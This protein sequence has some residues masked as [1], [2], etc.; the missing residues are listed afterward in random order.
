MKNRMKNEKPVIEAASAF[1][2]GGGRA[3]SVDLRG[4]SA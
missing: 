4:S 2:L 1:G 3:F